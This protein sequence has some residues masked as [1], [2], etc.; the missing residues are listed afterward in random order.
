MPQVH[1][2][3]GLTL[4]QTFRAR[5]KPD[6]AYERTV[7]SHDP[8]TVADESEA[9]LLVEAFGVAFS[10]EAGSVGGGT[11]GSGTYGGGTYG[12]LG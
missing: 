7:T 9:E 11:Y 1:P 3:A 12:T 5:H 8:I 4:P 6:A 2:N 10:R